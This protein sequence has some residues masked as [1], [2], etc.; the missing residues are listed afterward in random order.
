MRTRR[1]W[2]LGIA[3]VCS[4]VTTAAFARAQSSDDGMRKDLGVV[5]LKPGTGS[6]AARGYCLY[7]HYSGA[8]PNGQTFETSR[9]TSGDGREADPISFELGAGAVMAGWEKGLGGMRVGGIRQLWI[10]FK[11]A[12]GANGRPPAIPPRTD[13]VFDIEL[14][15]AVPALPNSSNAVRAESAKTCPAWSTLSRSK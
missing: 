3:F 6:R 15:A 11:L 1:A 10:P 2:L 7:V 13:L 14:L 12:Y 5:D 8:L 4:S 9:T